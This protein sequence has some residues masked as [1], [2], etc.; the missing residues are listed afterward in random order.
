MAWADANASAMTKSPAS[1][2]STLAQPAARN[3]ATYPGRRSA[4][5]AEPFRR[6]DVHRAAEMV[7]GRRGRQRDVQDDV[8]LGIDL[9]VPPPRMRRDRPHHRRP[10]AARNRWAARARSLGSTRTAVGWSRTTAS[11]AP[12]LASATPI[13]CS[14]ASAVV[15]LAVASSGGRSTIRSAPHSRAVAAMSGS[16]V[17]HTTRC[18]PPGRDRTAARGRSTPPDRRAGTRRRSAGSCPGPAGS[19][20]ARG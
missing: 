15:A 17:L 2:T 10:S 19:R 7:L 11:N 13:A 12:S 5:R 18:G 14:T 1:S 16:S 9:Q 8:G 4:A 3:P 20:H 6:H